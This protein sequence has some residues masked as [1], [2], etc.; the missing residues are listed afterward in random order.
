MT[1]KDKEIA[2]P[3]LDKSFRCPLSIYV[4]V[5]ERYLES[6][7]ACRR[8]EGIYDSPLTE[9]LLCC[10][11]ITLTPLYGSDYVIIILPNTAKNMNHD[12]GH[13]EVLFRDGSRIGRP[14]LPMTNDVASLMWAGNKGISIQ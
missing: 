2:I 13:S 4:E 12:P 14:S 1:D 10:S 11:N 3:W 6:G 7:G 5:M 9:I 8:I